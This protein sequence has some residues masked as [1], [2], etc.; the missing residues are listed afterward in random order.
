MKLQDLVRKKPHGV[1]R[2]ISHMRRKN[3]PHHRELK[4][5]IADGPGDEDS[6]NGEEYAIDL[7][8]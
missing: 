5:P 8:V 3:Q 7:N 6:A 4:D 2:E 1:K